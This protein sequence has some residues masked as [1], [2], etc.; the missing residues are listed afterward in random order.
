MGEKLFII[1][2]EDVD[3]GGE[4]CS[5]CLT[6]LCED[7]DTC[8]YGLCIDGRCTIP[9]ATAIAAGDSHTCALV[10][11]GRVR[12]WGANDKGQA[13]NRGD[14]HL[15]TVATKVGNVTTQLEG[16]TRIFAGPRNTCASSPEKLYC[17][18]A[19]RYQPQNGT[20]QTSF[21]FAESIQRYYSGAIVVEPGGPIFQNR[22]HDLSG[23]VSMGLGQN[24]A[25]VSNGSKAA[26]WGQ[27]D[28]GQLGFGDSSTVNKA[29]WG[30]NAL[31]GAGIQLAAGRKH[32]CAVTSAGA[33]SCWGSNWTN[34]CGKAATSDVT[35]AYAHPQLRSPRGRCVH[36]LRAE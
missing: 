30:D 16:M 15:R 11:K 20:A 12:C 23:V 19:I 14:S 4:S 7:D 34:Q 32:T 29:D 5:P 36:H 9:V 8:V 21:T 6:Q 26:C 27:N 35:R 18:G 24:H 31:S 3:C 13:G 28:N 1:N 25:C 10:Q 2:K 22:W 17:W 33:V